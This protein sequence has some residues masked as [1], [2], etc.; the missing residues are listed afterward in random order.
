MLWGVVGIDVK[1]VEHY[2]S[3]G[4]TTVEKKAHIADGSSR[5]EA[6]DN[7]IRHAEKTLAG[8]VCA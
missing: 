7:N 8:L 1:Q 5:S 3:L 2:A 4:A 6:I